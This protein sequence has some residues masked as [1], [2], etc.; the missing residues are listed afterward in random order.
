MTPEQVVLG[1]SI[2]PSPG[3]PTLAQCPF[4]RHALLSPSTWPVG[5]APKHP[6]H[7]PHGQADRVQLVHP[8][9]PQK[10]ARPS[11][12]HWL[13]TPAGQRPPRG[14]PSLRVCPKGFRGCC[15]GFLLPHQTR[16]VGPR[17][18][19]QTPGPLHST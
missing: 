18:R 3:G 2:L 1:R 17:G 5:E 8:P 10:Q 19:H 14:F 6:P 12:S 11:S 4:P 9:V 15:L 16:D 7:G 13:P